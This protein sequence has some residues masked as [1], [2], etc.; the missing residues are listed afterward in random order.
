MAFSTSPGLEMWE[1][2]ILGCNAPAARDDAALEWPP[3]PPTLEMRA[4]LFRLM[5]FDRTRVGLAFRQAELRQY[6]ENLICS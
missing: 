1:R 3:L 2:S 4:D 6:V 5:V